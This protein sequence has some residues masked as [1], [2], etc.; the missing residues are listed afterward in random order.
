MILYICPQEQQQTEA[1][2]ETTAHVSAC[3]Y[4]SSVRMILCMR[5]PGAA[6]GRGHVPKP[7]PAALGGA[8]SSLLLLGSRPFVGESEKKNAKT[9]TRTTTDLASGYPIYVCRHTSVGRTTGVLGITVFNMY[10]P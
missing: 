4:I 10:V 1:A 8:C 6:A 5:H 7:P 2:Y 3:Y 9:T